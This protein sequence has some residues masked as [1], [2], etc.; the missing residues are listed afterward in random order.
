MPEYRHLIQNVLHYLDWTFIS[1][2]LRTITPHEEFL[3]GKQVT[4]PGPQ[5]LRCLPAGILPLAAKN[6][7]DRFRFPKDINGTRCTI[8]SWGSQS[9]GKDTMERGK[10][11][12]EQ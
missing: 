5:V 4:S 1:C 9:P 8:P 10:T 11:K 7:R 12:K 6:S 3:S 2:L